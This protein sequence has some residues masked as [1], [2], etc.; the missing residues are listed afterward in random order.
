MLHQTS[1]KVTT[2]W[3]F[4]SCVNK[5]FSSGH[6]VEVKLLVSEACQK[7]VADEAWSSWIW[8]VSD[9]WWKGFTSDHDWDSSSFEFLLPKHDRDL[10]M[11]N[12]G[13]FCSG[14]SHHTEIVLWELFNK[15]LETIFNNNRALFMQMMFVLSIKLFTSMWVS[16][17]LMFQELDNLFIL[18]QVYLFIFI[19]KVTIFIA[20]E[21]TSTKIVHMFGNGGTILC[22]DSGDCVFVGLLDGFGSFCVGFL[23]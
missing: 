7:P 19:D 21:L 4:D 17:K 10:R 15:S 12:I 11:I 16:G 1:L 22:A 8:I 14:D 3:C 6:T 18:S 5:T 2:S 23:F 20:F 9:E 13:A